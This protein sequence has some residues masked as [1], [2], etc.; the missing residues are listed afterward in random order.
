MKSTHEVHSLQLRI[1]TNVYD[2]CG[3]F[4]LQSLLAT[5]L[6]GS[7]KGLKNSGQEVPAPAGVFQAYFATA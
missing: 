1:E 2:P 3:F 5:L 4:F 7:E 6:S